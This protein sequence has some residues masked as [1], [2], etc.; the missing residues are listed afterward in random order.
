MTV[1]PLDWNKNVANALL[2]RKAQSSFI[3]ALASST[4]NHFMTN[5][6]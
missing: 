2:K 3:E 5:A 6:H 4:L 1:H